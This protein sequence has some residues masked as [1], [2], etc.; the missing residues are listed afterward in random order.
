ILLHD[1]HHCA[2]S[3]SHDYIWIYGRCAFRITEKCDSAQTEQHK[4]PECPCPE[5]SGNNREQRKKRQDPA[6]F[7]EGLEAHKKTLFADPENGR[8]RRQNR[9][10]KRFSSNH[11]IMGSAAPS[12]SISSVSNLL[13]ATRLLVV[14]N[15][16]SAILLM[17]GVWPHF[18][19]ASSTRN[20][21]R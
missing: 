2:I 6:C 4:E 9:W 13:E 8:S 14:S 19:G 5:Q 10:R 7:P 1:V 11:N 16:F 21:G 20:S 3:G 12:G 17:W 15:P 18:Y